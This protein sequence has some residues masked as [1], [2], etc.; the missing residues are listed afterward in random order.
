MENYVR[1]AATLSSDSA[2]SGS[3]GTIVLHGAPADAVARLSARFPEALVATCRTLS[4]PDYRRRS[5]PVKGT[6]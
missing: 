5:E 3:G 1:T 6:A 4:R 2:I